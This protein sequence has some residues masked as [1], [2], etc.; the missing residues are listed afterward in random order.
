M[1]IRIKMPNN[2]GDKEVKRLYKMAKDNGYAISN[3]DQRKGKF[4]DVIDNVAGFDLFV[5]DSL[6]KQPTITY[7]AF[8]NER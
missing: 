6:K 1:S 4:F 3:P 7:E 2:Y 5:Q 8:F